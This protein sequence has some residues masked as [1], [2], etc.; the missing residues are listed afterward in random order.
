MAAPATSGTYAFAPA[1]DDFIAEAYSRIQIRGDQID[2]Q[3]IVDAE[4]SA[5]LM[6]VEWN[7]KGQNQFQLQLSVI[8]CSTVP[9]IQ[10]TGQIPASFFGPA[11]LQIFSS[12]C[13]TNYTP[14]N[15]YSGF[16]VPMI[17]LG[18]A[19]YEIIPFKLNPGRPDRFLWDTAALTI[20]GNYMQLWPIPV[21]A[22]AFTIR[23]WAFQRIQDAGGLTTLAP[24]KY[25][26]LEAFNCGLTARLAEKYMPSL[27]AEKTAL[28]VAAWTLAVSGGREHGPTRFR[29][30]P[31][32]AVSWR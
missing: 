5:N 22:A 14:G 2:T 9:N 16:S 24:V 31:R 10:T 23:A 32:N 19:D 27:F 6:M 25:E 4:R 12:V 7:N 11:P 20:A 30:D 1:E 13:I 29:V 3:K 17:R 15:P 8:P 28:A 18:R 26:W 21:P